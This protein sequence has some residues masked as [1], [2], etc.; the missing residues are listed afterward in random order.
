MP[1]VIVQVDIN[2]T[3]S[4]DCR[5]IVITDKSHA[6]FE[7]SPTTEGVHNIIDAQNHI[8]KDAMLRTN[9]VVKQGMDVNWLLWADL[10]FVDIDTLSKEKFV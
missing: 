1:R 9:L 7:A 6:C 4:H 8:T 10:T 5:D 3:S 2:T